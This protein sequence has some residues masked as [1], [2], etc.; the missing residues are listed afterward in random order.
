MKKPIKSKYPE[1]LEIRNRH[2]QATEELKEAFKRYNQAR[3]FVEKFNTEENYT[4]MAEALKDWDAKDQELDQIQ[5]EIN[6]FT[7]IKF[8]ANRKSNSL[9][10]AN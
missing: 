7:N 4:Q 2:F 1:L 9:E 6:K 3:K 10:E 5:S 8:Y